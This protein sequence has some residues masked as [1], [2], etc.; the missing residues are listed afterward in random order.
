MR[1]NI[2]I[3]SDCFKLFNMMRKVLSALAIVVAGMA[4]GAVAAVETVSA[5]SV[6][7][8]APTG[9]SVGLVLSGGGAKGIAEIGA[10]QALEDND[11][12]ID[13]IA[14]TSMGAIVGGLYACGYTPAEMMDMLLSKGFGYWSSGTIDPE[15]TYYFVKQP[16]TPAFA[17]INVNLSRRDSADTTPGILP[18]SLISPLP[19]NF[20]FM[21]LFAAYTAQCGSDF[22]NLFVPFRCV[23]SDITAK[24]K[25]VCRSG[26]LSDAIRASMSFPC[27]FAP[28]KMNGVYVYDGGLYDNFPVDVMR[29]DFA[30]DIMIGVDVH[31]SDKGPQPHNIITTI[32]NMAQVKQDYK[33]PEDEGIHVRINVSEFSLLDW[34]KA[35]ELYDIGYKKTMSMMDSIKARVTSRE[36][37]QS[38]T[39]RRRVFKSKS[40]YVR[41]DSVH[42]VGGTRAQNE[43]LSHLFKPEKVDTFGI[44][45]AQMSYYRALSPGKLR[46]LMPQADYNKSNGLFTLSL[47][48][49]VK[50][51]FSVGAGGYLTSSAN[52]FIFLSA[53]YS[54]MSYRSTEAKLMGWI[55]QSY[56]A[57]E[58]DGRLYLTN[59]RP[60]AF[61]L[62]AVYSRQKYYENDKLFYEDSSPAFITNYNAFARLYFGWAVGN[63]GKVQ[64]G[65]GGG[66]DRNGFYASDKGDFRSSGKVTTH[67]NLG[68]AI[69][70]LE[71]NALNNQSYPSEGY[72]IKVTAME[73]I[74]KYHYDERGGEAGDVRESDPTHWFQAEAHMENYIPLGKN[75]SL[76]MNAE[77]LFSTRDLLN[78]YYASLVNAPSFTPT[79]ATRN[80]FNKRFRAN[81]FAAV[82]V[83][84]IWRPMQNAQVRLNANVFMPFRRIE[85]GVDGVEARYGGWFRNPEFVGELDLVYNLPFASVCAYLNYLTYPARNWN[86]GLSFG[87]FFTAG[88]LLR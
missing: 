72:L 40:P 23:T 59:T 18:A 68:Q 86:V 39:L 24:K 83:T 55:G 7:A 81:S 74:G 27:V 67:F 57:A 6:T 73:V 20:A 75:F 54:S 77:V 3:V 48:A 8:P 45:S 31:A 56:M 33:L 64:I 61:D 35:K 5:D 41:F 58:F 69:G 36:T 34:G 1:Y 12:P 10:I 70:R 9:Q 21:D 26:H 87:L 11:I 62:E 76:G 4:C 49:D 84:P 43:Y 50:D 22:N 80:V 85:Q 88:R 37:A 17:N 60:S 53:N 38:R 82:G 66:Q 65:I 13:Y 44:H 78:T 28:I 19:M 52:S 47:D 30:P 51:N 79:P 29:E 15:L 46:N 32:E 71:F 2:K 25:I 42:V 14:G 16:Q 63:R